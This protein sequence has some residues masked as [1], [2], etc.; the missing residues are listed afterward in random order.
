MY[1]R[2]MDKQSDLS[3]FASWKK[4]SLLMYFLMLDA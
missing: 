4:K 2:E 3:G 1:H